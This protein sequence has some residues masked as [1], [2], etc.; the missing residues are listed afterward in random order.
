MS[1]IVNSDCD[2]LR[3]D[4]DDPKGWE[5]RIAESRISYDQ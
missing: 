4:A 2:S 5:A 1:D 3:E